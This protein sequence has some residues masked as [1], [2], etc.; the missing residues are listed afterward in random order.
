MNRLANIISTITGTTRSLP[1]TVA[2]TLVALSLLASTALSSCSNFET[3]GN[4]DFDGYWQLETIDTLATGGTTDM[5]DSLVFWAVQHHLIE[6]CSRQV[7]PATY[8]YKYFSVFYH[9][10]RSGDTLHFI[11]DSLSQPKDMPVIDLRSSLDPYATIGQVRVY[12]L[13]RFDETFRILQLDSDEMTLE[14][15]VFRMHFRKY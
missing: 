10:R 8:S 1:R 11:A 13:S 15:D 3:S 12:G 14:S 4:G 5:H 6:L 2:A 7:E 9:F